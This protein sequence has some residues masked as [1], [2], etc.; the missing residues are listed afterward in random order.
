VLNWL[1]SLHKPKEKAE[2]AELVI[3]TAEAP[4]TSDDSLS[5]QRNIVLRD[6]YTNEESLTVIEVSTQDITTRSIDAPED[7]I[8]PL[9][10]EAPEYQAIDEEVRAQIARKLSRLIPTLE[11]KEKEA[12]YEYTIR[13]LKTLAEDQAIRI[14]RI[15]SEELKTLPNVPHELVYRLASDAEA[16]VATPML[17]FSPLL[18]D[19][20]LLEIIS[21]SQIPAICDAIAQRQKVSA[22][23]S[24]AIAETETA[25]AINHLLENTGATIDADTFDS[26]AKSAL[27]NVEIQPSLL[28]HPDLP[29]QTLNRLASQISS[30]MLDE[31][32][33]KMQMRDDLWQTLS[34][35]VRSRLM[36]LQMDRQRNADARA[37]A[38]FEN[39]QLDQEAIL[40]A[41]EQRDREF[42]I[43]ALS[44]LSGL[45]RETVERI[46]QSK[47]ARAVTAL[48]WK[49][50]LSMRTAIQIQLRIAQI[51]H[52]RI[53]NAKGGFD[54]PVS[55]QEMAD[56]LAIFTKE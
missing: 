1:K 36:N 46:I 12:A 2:A 10:A 50:G 20:D 41:I 4:P 35:N 3:P 31:L 30:R 52:T 22:V 39:N 28:L 51:H 45:L 56:Y 43:S 7:R 33:Y 24:R 21:H 32:M 27:V 9:E 38:M 26:M 11:D 29:L 13:V 54:Y 55:E 14:R 48:S 47:N 44:L 19:E 40:E 23:V 42:V 8:A 18:T 53:L 6:T 25:S 34:S 49:S 15:I 16:S 37:Q 17:Q 5:S